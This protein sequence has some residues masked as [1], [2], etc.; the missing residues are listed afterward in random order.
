M[1]RS[2]ADIFDAIGN[3]V[4]RT[5]AERQYH[6][7]DLPPI[8]ADV[9]TR[10]AP[11]RACSAADILQYVVQATAFPFQQ[12]DASRFGEPP[13]TVYWHPRFYIEAL[14]WMAGSPT[15][16]NHAFSGAFMV[17]EGR[18]LH[19]EFAFVTEE[20]HL[21]EIAFGRMAI[22]GSTLCLPGSVEL[23]EAGDEFVHAVFHTGRPGLSLVVR[24]HSRSVGAG[25]QYLPPCLRIGPAFEDQLTRRQLQALAL[26]LQIESPDYERTAAHLIARGDMRLTVNV[27][28][29]AA[30][31]APHSALRPA[32]LAHAR[33]RWGSRADDIDRCLTFQLRQRLGMLGRRRLRDPDELLCLGLL[34]QERG[35]QAIGER[36][37]EWGIT[38]APG[39]WIAARLAAL[40]ARGVWGEGLTTDARE[41]M[42]AAAR[43]AADDG[44]RAPDPA[45]A[46]ADMLLG[47]LFAA[48]PPVLTPTPAR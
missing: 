15:A 24:T 16:H 33:A 30:D 48:A 25:R 22:T 4:A 23:I 44:G 36:L 19:T 26:L 21:D 31:V 18:S 3:E 8:A 38:D 29:Q 2:C 11:H 9:L 14:F 41:L 46:R 5:W 42:C 47:P 7:R 45:L 34:L 10:F 28:Q 32:V 40:A 1:T 37:R 17:M 35:W 20:T 27:L 39:G 43:D 12:N 6:D 13:I